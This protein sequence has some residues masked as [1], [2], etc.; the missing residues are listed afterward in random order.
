MGN[1]RHYGHIYN[2][3]GSI[4]VSH[5]FIQIC[6]CFIVDF[7]CL[8]CIYGIYNPIYNKSIVLILFFSLISQLITI[9]YLL[10]T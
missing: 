3:D 6:H 9:N 7:F 5:I 10:L 4:Y 1:S 8:R 2:F